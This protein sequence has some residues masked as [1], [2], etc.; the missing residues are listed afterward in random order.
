MINAYLNNEFSNKWFKF[1]LDN[2][3]KPLNRFSEL[4]QQVVG[5]KLKQ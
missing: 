5:K 1:I 3:D 4:R 2:Q